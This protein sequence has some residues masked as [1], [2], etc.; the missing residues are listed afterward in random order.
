MILDSKAPFASDQ[1]P[2]GT[3]RDPLPPGGLVAFSSPHSGASTMA[4][5]AL[6]AAAVAL[7]LLSLLAAVWSALTGAACPFSPTPGP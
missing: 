3:L 1:A 4:R 5:K 7:L 6:I 2:S